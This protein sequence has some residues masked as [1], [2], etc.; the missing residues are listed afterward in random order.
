MKKKQRPDRI[1]SEQ[2]VLERIQERAG[3]RY[4]SAQLAAYFGIPTARMTAVLSAL[5]TAK[6][7]RR[8][9]SSCSPTMYYLPSA[10]ELKAESRMPTGFLSP[11]V[12]IKVES[13]S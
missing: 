2:A 3:Y 10:E 13:E 9:R 8:V 6:R 1:F 12:V 7:I 4:Q 5:V 11:V